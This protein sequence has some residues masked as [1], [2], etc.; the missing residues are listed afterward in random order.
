M[1][2]KDYYR[3]D[4][5]F[6][7]DLVE[8]SVD[9]FDLA[10]TIIAISQSLNQ[11]SSIKYE[12][13]EEKIKI[14][15]NAFKGGSF[16]SE[17]LIFLEQSRD[18]VTP[19]IPIALNGY[20]IGKDILSTLDTYIKVRKTLKGK[21]PSKVVHTNEGVTIYAS[22]NAKVT[23]NHIDFRAIQDTRIAKN[24]DKAIQPLLKPESEIKDI[25]LTDQEKKVISVNRNEAEY[26]RE[27]QIFQEIDNHVLK[28]TVTKIDRKTLAGFLTLGDVKTGKRVSF[29]FSGDLAEDK[30]HF[31]ITSLEKKVKIYI[32]G[33]LKTDYESNPRHI[34]VTDVRQDE[35]LF[36]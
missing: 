28:G 18:L 32:R 17:F 31:L 24:I 29:T 27:N 30:F 9:A 23:V 14:N 1:E 8:N 34:D 11:I 7:G 16:I 22:D 6:N 4:L 33:K 35:D 20:Q 15:V 5:S 26:L 19:F 21:P 3:F 13:L 36:G 10:N 25:S 12:H 2:S